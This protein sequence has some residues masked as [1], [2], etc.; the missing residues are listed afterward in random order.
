MITALYSMVVS[1]GLTMYDSNKLWECFV[2]VTHFS[3]SLMSNALITF[4][5]LT[6]CNMQS[7]LT[8]SWLFSFFVKLCVIST[9]IHLFYRSTYGYTQHFWNLD[10]Q[11]LSTISLCQGLSNTSKKM[12]SGD[13]AVNMWMNISRKGWK[14]VYILE[15]QKFGFPEIQEQLKRLAPS[16][17]VY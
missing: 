8:T 14:A 9:N 2:N 12:F 11:N 4:G 5:K 13:E 16:P 3:F 10:A 7:M 1:F 17:I 6:W 15:N